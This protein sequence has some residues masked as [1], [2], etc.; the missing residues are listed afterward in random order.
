MEAEGTGGQEG[1]WGRGSAVICGETREGGDANDEGEKN[2]RS[3]L[4]RTYTCGQSDTRGPLRPAEGPSGRSHSPTLSLNLPPMSAFL[5]YL[6]CLA[7]PTPHIHP[8]SPAVRHAEEFPPV[9]Q[10]H[11]RPNRSEKK[12]R[13]AERDWNPF[14]VCVRA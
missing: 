4:E 14:S 3:A 13:C 2:A 12:A 9:S 1:I 5:K 7:A 8:E 11:Q 10:Q 6:C